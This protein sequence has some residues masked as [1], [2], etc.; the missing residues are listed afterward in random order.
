MRRHLTKYL[1]YTAAL[2]ARTTSAAMLIKSA[3][4]VSLFDTAR[5]VCGAGSIKLSG[6]RPSVR[7]VPSLA[8][9]TP[10]WRVRC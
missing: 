3:S 1:S 4:A 8:R 9:R 2:Y 10:L 5:I 7:P 6:V